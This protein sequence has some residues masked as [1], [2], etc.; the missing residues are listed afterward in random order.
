MVRS[1]LDNPDGQLFI[2]SS[3]WGVDAS[4][5]Y[6]FYVSALPA[7]VVRTLRDDIKYLKIPKKSL[8][9]NLVMTWNSNERGALADFC[10]TN[11]VPVSKLETEQP[12]LA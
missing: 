9:K 12:S 4:F 8:T 10:H 1:Y 2:R 11:G 5:A 3:R 7:Y 6:A